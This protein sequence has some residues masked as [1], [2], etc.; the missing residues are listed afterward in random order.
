MEHEGSIWAFPQKFCMHFSTVPC[1][2]I[3]YYY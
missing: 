3:L 1:V 2:L